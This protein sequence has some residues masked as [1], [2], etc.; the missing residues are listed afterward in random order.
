MLLYP[1]QEKQPWFPELLFSFKLFLFAYIL[2]NLLT[3]H[4]EQ[5]PGRKPARDVDFSMHRR[6][7]QALKIIFRKQ[8][9]HQ[10]E[11]SA[12]STKNRQAR[13]DI[14]SAEQEYR[15]ALED[16]NL[17]DEPTKEEELLLIK[18]YAL[19][20]SLDAVLWSKLEP[21]KQT[22][23]PFRISAK[24]HGIIDYAFAATLCVAPLVFG[25]KN[26]FLFGLLGDAAALSAGLTKDSRGVLPV[27]P[28]KAHRAVDVALL[29]GLALAATSKS[30]R[31]H[32]PSLIFTLGMLAAGVT[33]VL[34]TDWNNNAKS[35]KS[36]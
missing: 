26:K 14:H 30:V 15:Q 10:N 20:P 31:K 28:L 22:K 19:D 1:A 29:S 5:F 9:F 17:S 27:M 11:I 4:T 32:K 7:A 36:I 16:H 3:A 25:L 21:T 33:T 13:I 2:S 35:K 18:T 12:M 23:V 8:I 34:L 24:T 6:L